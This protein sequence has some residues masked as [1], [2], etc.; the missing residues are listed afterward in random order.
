[1][2][3]SKRVTAKFVLRKDLATPNF[4]VTS[5]DR[6]QNENARGVIAGVLVLSISSVS[7]RVG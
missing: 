4:T 5:L 7:N 2:R 6:Q 3:L 1:M